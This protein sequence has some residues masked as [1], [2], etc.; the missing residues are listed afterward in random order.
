MSK[1]NGG[2]AV[3]RVRRKADIAKAIVEARKRERA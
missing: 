2:V 3:Y 1:Q